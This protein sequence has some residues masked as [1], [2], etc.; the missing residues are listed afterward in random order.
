M[1]LPHNTILAAL[2]TQ[3][4]SHAEKD[5][6]FYSRREAVAVEWHHQHVQ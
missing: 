5:S 1:S 2:N 6:L 4:V 3:I